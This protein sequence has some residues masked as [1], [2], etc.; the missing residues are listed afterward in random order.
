MDELDAL[1]AEG[2]REL[3]TKAV[4][5]MSPAR[6]ARAPL[7]QESR[8]VQLAAWWDYT[9]CSCGFVN[10]HF[11][12]LFEEREMRQGGGRHWV[13]LA[14]SRPGAS[15]VTYIRAHKSAYCA[16]CARIDA[17]PLAAEYTGPGTN[18][19]FVRVEMRA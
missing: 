7:E 17:W 19:T 6:A 10:Q 14:T 16:N 9:T 5:G 13:R 2:F 3:P 1:I 12:G 11:D 15:G 8:F 4:P 18:P